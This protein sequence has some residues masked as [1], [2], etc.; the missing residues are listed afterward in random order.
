MADSNV[1][2]SVEVR[3]GG[4]FGFGVDRA[5]CSIQEPGMWGFAPS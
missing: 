5:M 2:V 4:D 3:G 1:N